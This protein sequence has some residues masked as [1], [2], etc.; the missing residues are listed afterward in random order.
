MKTIT[1]VDPFDELISEIRDILPQYRTF[2]IYRQSSSLVEMLQLLISDLSGVTEEN[3]PLKLDPRN[4]RAWNSLIDDLE[5]RYR[6]SP[7]NSYG[8]SFMFHAGELKHLVDCL[9]LHRLDA[10]RFSLARMFE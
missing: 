3:E 1:K 2:K 4:N 5:A 10:N 8:T 6:S 9:R 7:E